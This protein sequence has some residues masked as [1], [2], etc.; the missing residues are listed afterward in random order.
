MEKGSKN[1][2]TLLTEKVTGKLICCDLLRQRGTQHTDGLLIELIFEKIES[3]WLRGDEL[4][5]PPFVHQNNHMQLINDFWTA[6]QSQ[7]H[8]YKMFN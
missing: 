8:A 3:R 5:R 1:N 2:G 4:R 7:F 6:E